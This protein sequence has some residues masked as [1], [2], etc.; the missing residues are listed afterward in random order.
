MRKS[1]WPLFIELLTRQLGPC[2]NSIPLSI[3]GQLTVETVETHEIINNDD[4]PACS[5][6]S[7]LPNAWLQ[8]VGNGNIYTLSTCDE[9]TKAASILNVLE[10][11]TCG[12]LECTSIQEDASQDCTASEFASQISWATTPGALYRVLVSTGE[13]DTSIGIHL[14]EQI[15]LSNSDTT[16]DGQLPPSNDQC[17]GAI[18]LQIDSGVIGSTVDTTSKENPC[19]GAA[20]TTRG[21][22]YKVVGT[23]ERFISSTCSNSTTTSF[24]AQ[25]SVYDGNTDN[26]NDDCTEE[27]LMICKSRSVGDSSCEHGDAQVASWISEVNQ[28]YFIY[29]HGNDDNATGSFG[30]SL[31]KFVRNVETPSPTGMTPTT[32]TN[33]PALSPPIIT[34]TP[35]AHPSNLPT[36]N[37]PLE[38]PSD[39]PSSI[40]S[41]RPSIVASASPS[42]TPTP[43]PTTGVPSDHPTDDGGVRNDSYRNAIWIFADDT[44][45]YGST[46]EA[47]LDTA[48]VGHFC[49]TSIAAPGV[50]YALVGGGFGVRLSTCS[51]ATAY[52]TSL[53]VF[54]DDLGTLP[55]IGGG[56]N[57]VRCDL[58]AK[59]STVSFFG[60]VGVSYYI[61][62]HG[63]NP[64]D[65]G[66]FGLQV[67][68]FSRVHNDECESAE[69][70]NADGELH[71]GSTVFATI[72]ETPQVFYCGAFVGVNNGVWYQV[73]GT[74][75]NFTASTCVSPETDYNTALSVFGGTCGVFD[76]DLQ[77]VGGNDDDFE[78]QGQFGKSTYTWQTEPS[79]VYYILVHGSYFSDTLE[80]FLSGYGDF[81]L[82]L[83]AT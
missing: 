31:H 9:A 77:C 66:F 12:E 38:N 50:W 71:M 37:I 14:T 34:D 82:M 53:S 54:S 67:S 21:V 40:P 2:S 30:L 27:G 25:I 41:A 59:T 44:T 57:N 22:F 43:R 8:V 20:I 61:L 5:F 42:I 10:G 62:V 28:T 35:S 76:E 56:N 17:V 15:P 80:I 29:I 63:G 48:E 16:V 58:D 3:G 13:P 72:E 19:G 78:C 70:L 18:T 81:G 55:C 75:E 36:A 69:S 11:P 73:V 49:G 4:I 68:S 24:N 83:T 60:K 1:N 79:K 47:T 52:D 7:D 32:T 51:R 26:L 65:V 74:G 6:V 46:A 33:T 45:H 23:G 39:S 64:G